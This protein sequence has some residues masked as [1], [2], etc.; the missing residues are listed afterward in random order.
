M[1]YVCVT[2]LVDTRFA[3]CREGRNHTTPIPNANELAS[4]ISTTTVCRN[5][6]KPGHFLSIVM[7]GSS[8]IGHIS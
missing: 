3:W 7:K 8:G 5:L 2:K 6:G 4:A 1:W